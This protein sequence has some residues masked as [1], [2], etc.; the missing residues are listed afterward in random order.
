MTFIRGPV[1]KGQVALNVVNDHFWL[2]FLDPQ[3]DRTVQDADFL[4]DNMKEFRIPTDGSF[5][6]RMF[7]MWRTPWHQTYN[8]DY[9]EARRDLYRKYYEKTGDGLSEDIIWQ[10]SPLNGEKEENGSPALTVFRHFNSASVVKGVQGGLPKT[11]WVMDFPLMERIYYALV[12]GFNVYGHMPHQLSTRFFMDGLR[13]E[14]ETLF[15]DFIKEPV[16]RKTM[17]KWYGIE[18]ETSWEFKRLRY[19]PMDGL[20]SGIDYQSD[21]HEREVAE[22]FVNHIKKR[23]GLDFDDNYLVEQNGAVH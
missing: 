19:R 6:V 23:Y 15:L 17:A 10:G 11:L 20:P 13:Q 2:F 1:C 22:R 21:K 4:K 5:L 8:E 7:F 18:S 16:R 12:A 3:H 9:V 14:G